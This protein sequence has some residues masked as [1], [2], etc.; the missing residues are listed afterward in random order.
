MTRTH[1]LPS[2]FEKLFHHKYHT[3]MMSHAFLY[4]DTGNCHVSLYKNEFKNFK[5]IVPYH[6]VVAIAVLMIIVLGHICQ[7]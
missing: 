3:D 2:S 5:P 6:I 7:H 1:P 4:V